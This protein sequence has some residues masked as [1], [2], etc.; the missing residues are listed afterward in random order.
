[1]VEVYIYVCPTPGCGNYYAS[2]TFTEAHGISQPQ[3]ARKQTGERVEIHNRR[4][5][6]NCGAQRQPHKLRVNERGKSAAA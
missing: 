5:C 1:M 2:P 6:P 4:A 3:S